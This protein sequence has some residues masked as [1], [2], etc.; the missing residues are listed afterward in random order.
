MA[1]NFSKDIKIQTSF[2]GVLIIFI[3]FKM[4]VKILL[5]QLVYFSLFSMY[6]ISAYFRKITNS[7]IYFK[8][9]TE[10]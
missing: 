6:Q 4:R 1:K 8:L 5:I 7:I 2:F 3:N 10:G 9:W